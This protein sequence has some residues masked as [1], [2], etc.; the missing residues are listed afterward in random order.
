MEILKELIGIIDRHKI[1]QIDLVTNSGPQTSKVNDL[2]QLIQS[3]EISDDTNASMHFYNSTPELETYKKLK[4]RLQ[5][6]LVNTIF[7]IDFNQPSFNEAQKAYYISY[8]DLAAAKILL[9]RGARKAAIQLAE[10]IFFIAKKFEFTDIGLATAQILQG[11]Y[12]PIMGNNKRYN[13]YR[14]YV[15][16]YAEIYHAEL[17]AEDYYNDLAI[18]YSKSKSTKTEILEIAIQYTKEL[19][20]YTSKYVS[21]RL[22]LYAY[23]VYTFRYLIEND[24][25]KTLEVC[26]KAIEIFES[27]QV[28]YKGAI[29]N[30]LLKMLECHIQLRQYKEGEKV[31]LKCLAIVPSGN[32][33][34]FHTLELYLLLS[35]HTKKY[36]K[37]FE[38]YSQAANHRKF[39]NLKQTS[40]EYWKIYNAYIEF[41]IH[42]DKMN[43]LNASGK[44]STAK[45]KLGKFLNE[46]PTFSK[47]KR[48]VNINILILQ[49]LFLLQKKDFGTIIDRME[50]LEAY[51]YR[52]LRKDDTFRSNCFLKMLLLLPKAG[53][54]RGRI[55][56]RSKSYLEKL[57]AV[58]LEQA[59][60]SGQ[61]EIIPYETLWEFVVESL[62]DRIHHY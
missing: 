17:F 25:K 16:E 39:K 23:M 30:F 2:Y 50:A 45:F 46:V 26:T 3:G 31:A 1:K 62:D 21:Y 48:G 28:S 20:V 51:C 4:Y 13:F 49:I 44:L 9:G 37:T 54:H 56:H 38:I 7:F 15:K 22:N 8:K 43:G 41:L 59:N 40:S 34:W 58:P 12:G 55:E 29:T 52:H 14:K 47:D 61:I 36:Q 32:A 57:K 27:K 6:R 11:H 24:Y 60:Q 10:R 35:L 42:M 18:N 53:F 19:E 5:K 33:N